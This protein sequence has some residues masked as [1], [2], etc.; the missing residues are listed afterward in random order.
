MGRQS[1]HLLLLLYTKKCKQAAFADVTRY[2]CQWMVLGRR[3]FFGTL[4]SCTR[5]GSVSTASLRCELVRFSGN[6]CI[7]YGA[8]RCHVSLFVVYRT[9]R[10]ARSRK[11][12]GAV[13]CGFRYRTT[14]GAVSYAVKTP[15][16]L[17]GMAIVYRCRVCFVM[18]CRS[19]DPTKPAHTQC[20]PDSSSKRFYN[21]VAT[22]MYVVPDR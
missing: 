4:P 17:Y 11:T 7:T 8:F 1:D 3:C 19:L 22:T 12:Y 14:C 13:R 15:G 10:F 2:V 20:S 16:K 5:C 6:K 9:V 21:R 18:V